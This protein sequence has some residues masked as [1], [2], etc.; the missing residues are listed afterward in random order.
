MEKMKLLIIGGTGVLSTAV[1]SEAIKSGIEVSILNRGNRLERIPQGVKLFKS[2]ARDEKRVR[3][4]LEGNTFDAVIDFICFTQSQIEYSLSLFSQY[5]K[6][7][8]FISTTCVY[9]T[10]IP[11]VKDE[12]SPKV[13]KE[14]DYSVNKWDCEKYLVSAAKEKGIPFTIIRPCITYDDTR[15]PYG[16]TPPYGYHW[17]LVERIKTGKPIITWDGGRAKWN[18]MRVEDFAVGVC[19]LIGNEDSF[20]EAYNISGDEAYSWEE[21]LKVLE[22]IFHKD[23]VKVD[24]PS[25]VYKDYLKVK[26]GEISGRALD[27]TVSNS[28]IKRI[29]PSYNTKIGIEEGIMMTVN[30]YKSKNY[31]HGIDWKFDADT[32]RIIKDWCKKKGEDWKKYKLGF[33][34]YLGTATINDRLLYWFVFNNIYD[35]YRFLGR[36]KKKLKKIFA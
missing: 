30:A 28:K 21:I 24:M 18:M 33:I 3:Q 1:V 29:C 4:L 25:R 34:D 13:L 14:W 23:I 27:C 11:G 16:I 19:S 36:I 17:T 15:I 32:D 5:A 20:G 35:V 6:Q 9:N 26:S 2:D 8:L 22:D 10:S 31:Q 7:Y 12:D